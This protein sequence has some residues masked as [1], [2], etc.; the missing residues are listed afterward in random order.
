M[1]RPRSGND[2][3]YCGLCHGSMRGTPFRGMQSRSCDPIASKAS[4]ERYQAGVVRASQESQLCR[5]VKVQVAESAL[6]FRELS[7]ASNRHSVSRTSV[8]DVT[9]RDT[10]RVTYLL[11][12]SQLYSRQPP[13]LL[14]HPPCNN[15]QPH[16]VLFGN[17]FRKVRCEAQVAHAQVAHR[18]L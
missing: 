5:R 18:S 1:R 9:S 13:R 12:A 2:G 8:C 17:W 14:R 15:T 3:I 7:R 4:T 10:Q 6:A 16:M 11:G